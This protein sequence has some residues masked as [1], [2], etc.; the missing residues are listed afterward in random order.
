MAR[1]ATGQELVEA[2]GA[3]DKVQEEVVFLNK[4]KGGLEELLFRKTAE[5][6]KLKGELRKVY[7]SHEKSSKPPKSPTPNDPVK[8]KES[9]QA[10]AD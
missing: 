4:A 6:R 3:L 5:I 10:L 9:D 2:S 7:A 1:E 8:G